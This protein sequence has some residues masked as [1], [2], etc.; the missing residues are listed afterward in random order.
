MALWSTAVMVTG[1]DEYLNLNIGMQTG[2]PWRIG[3]QVCPSI[4]GPPRLVTV[5]EF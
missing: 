3:L 5:P 2:C 1:D 4:K